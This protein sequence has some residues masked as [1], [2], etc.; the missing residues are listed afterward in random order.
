[1][2]AGDKK[3]KFVSADPMQDCGL[4]TQGR[5]R[6]SYIGSRA[7]SATDPTGFDIC[8]LG[9]LTYFTFFPLYSFGLGAGGIQSILVEDV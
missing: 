8:V 4:S 9:S 1:M 3:P 2:A 7:L 5:N 6:S